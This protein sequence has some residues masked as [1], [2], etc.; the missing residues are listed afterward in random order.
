M[1]G[2]L[3]EAVAACPGCGRAGGGCPPLLR[4][5]DRLT[6][7]PGQFSVLRCEACGLAYTSPRLRPQDFATYYPSDYSAYEPNVAASRPSLGERVGAWQRQLVIRFG[8]YRR[9]WQLPPGR[10]LDVGCGVGDLAA[11][12]ARHGWQACGVEPSARA[13]EHARAAGVDAV[14]GTL[15][16]APWP[17]ASFDAILFN[18]SLEH[19]GDPAATLAAATRLLRPGGLLAIA[20]PNFDSW[21]RRLFGSAWFQ[22]DLPRHLQHFDRDSLSGLVE[23]AGLETVATGS[24]TMR[25]SPLGS[26]QYAG[27]GRLR[28]A[29]RGFRLLAW[30]ITPL[31]LLSDRVAAGDC[32]HLLARRPAQPAAGRSRH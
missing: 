10:L 12:F 31:L 9:I 32:L 27:F 8:P 30:A 22:L 14:A 18:H 15:D 28:F 24:A 7:A 21:H 11:A 25:P 4:G 29:G 6:G 16:D 23:R 3:A 20:V 26:L 19:V 1:S 13:V 5:H 2:A 17:L